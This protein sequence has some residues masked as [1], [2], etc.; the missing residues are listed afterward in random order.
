MLIVNHLPPKNPSKQQRTIVLEKK[1]TPVKG[2]FPAMIKKNFLPESKLYR[3]MNTKIDYESQKEHEQLKR[4][5]FSEMKDELDF[6][7]CTFNPNLDEMSMTQ[8]IQQRRVKIQEREVPNRYRREYLET[9]ELM[10]KQDLEDE[11]LQT[12]RIPNN[13]DKTPNPNFY[14]EK[15]EWKDKVLKKT[16]KMRNN[17]WDEERG[18]LIGQPRTNDYNFGEEIPEFLDRVDQNIKR[19]E[20]YIKNL[21]SKIYN[22]PF[23]PNL[24]LTARENELKYQ[25][26]SEPNKDVEEEI[27]NTIEYSKE[28]QAQ[29]EAERWELMD[30]K[31]KQKEVLKKSISEFKKKFKKRK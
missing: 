25:Y 12:L 22:H 28:A 10:R 19:K 21:D 31:E 14:K 27:E 20:K 7:E 4:Q 1:F 2:K 17:K 6:K 13:Q 16:N 8:A 24:S 23:K 15:K 18:T 29:E 26:F 5:R 30:E 11:E 9:Q 3:D